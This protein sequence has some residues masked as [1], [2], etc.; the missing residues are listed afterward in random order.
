M[1]NEAWQTVHGEESVFPKNELN[2]SPGERIGSGSFGTVCYIELQPL[3]IHYLFT[4]K[5]NF[6][7]VASRSSALA[8]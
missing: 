1:I 2:C 4:F 6:A 8:L 5:T 3:L 7:C